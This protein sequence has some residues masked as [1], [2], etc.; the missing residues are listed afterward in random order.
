[1]YWTI[2]QAK[3]SKFK[4]NIYVSSEDEKILKFSR[5]LCVNTITRPISLCHEVSSCDSAIKNVLDNLNFNVKNIIFLQATSPLRKPKDIDNAFK[6]MVNTK[7]DHFF[8]TKLKIILI[9]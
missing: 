8:V 7:S 5:K 6:K 4:K 2:L 1:M 9:F 3:K